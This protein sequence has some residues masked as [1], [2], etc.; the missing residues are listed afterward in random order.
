[1]RTRH[2]K[3]NVYLN[4]NEKKMLEEKSSKMKLSQSDFLK[5]LI[6]DYSENKI[7]NKDIE[8]IIISLSDVYNNLFE[9]LNKLNR[10]CY[11]DFAYFLNEQIF[12]IKKQLEK[13]KIKI[14]EKAMLEF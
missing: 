10:L 14:I 2:I 5:M 8:E 6:Q 7:L 4:E 1:M 3:I 11:Y 9:L 13:F 12:N